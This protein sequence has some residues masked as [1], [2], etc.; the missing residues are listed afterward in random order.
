VDEANDLVASI[1][2]ARADGLPL[3]ISTGSA[4]ERRQAVDVVVFFGVIG[5]T[6][7]RL[8]FHA[9]VLHAH[10]AVVSRGG[11]AASEGMTRTVRNNGRPQG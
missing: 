9:G 6:I 2:I 5:V 10:S 8:G 11:A 7:F 3:V 1:T 4:S